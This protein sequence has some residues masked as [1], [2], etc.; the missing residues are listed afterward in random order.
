MS[1]NSRDLKIIVTSQYLA[2]NGYESLYFALPL[3]DN[4]PEWRVVEH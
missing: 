4:E 3:S 2:G 1:K